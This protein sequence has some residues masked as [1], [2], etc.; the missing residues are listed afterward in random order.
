MKDKLKYVCEG[1]NNAIATSMSFL[2]GV[3]LTI[4]SFFADKAWCGI[5][6]FLFGV[7]LTVGGIASAYID[8][9]RFER[10]R[11]LEQKEL[12]WKH[13]SPPIGKIT[14]VSLVEGGGVSIECELK[15]AMSIAVNGREED[16]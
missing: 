2:F 5:L 3:T 14:E 8:S 1:L 15:D 7:A 4:S 12:R 16:S 11:E 6:W 10:L 9:K 13:F